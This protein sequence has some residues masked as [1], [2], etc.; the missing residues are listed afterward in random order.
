MKLPSPMGK[1]H[2]GIPRGREP[3]QSSFCSL[4]LSNGPAYAAAH[5]GPLGR[6]CREARATTEPAVYSLSHHRRLMTPTVRVSSFGK[7]V[8]TKVWQSRVAS[9]TLSHSV[10]GGT[11]HRSPMHGIYEVTL[12]RKRDLLRGRYAFV[13]RFE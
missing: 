5:T 11:E 3:R 8:S 7:G 6:A 10:L 13:K 9:H 4:V 1:P 12:G 2:C